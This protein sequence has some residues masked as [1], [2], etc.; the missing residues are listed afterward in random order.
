MKYILLIFGFNAGDGT[1]LSAEFNTQS[2]CESAIVAM[3]DRA[4]SGNRYDSPFG[5]RN[6]EVARM[7]VNMSVC[8][9]KGTPAQ[10]E[11]G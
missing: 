11:P 5:S 1:S 10:E 7:I 3:T 8:V 2:A 6:T 9:P 4:L